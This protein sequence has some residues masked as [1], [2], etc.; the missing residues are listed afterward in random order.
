MEI[1]KFL[2]RASPPL[3]CMRFLHNQIPL[4]CFVCCFFSNIQNFKSESM[5]YLW[6]SCEDREKTRDFCDNRIK[7]YFIYRNWK[8]TSTLLLS[9]C[10][11]YGV[12]M[13]ILNFI[14][15]Q[16][17]SGITLEKEASITIRRC[18][19][20]NSMERR[21]RNIWKRASVKYLKKRTLRLWHSDIALSLGVCELWM[22][23][24]VL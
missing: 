4:E 5:R 3:I 21:L 16:S 13:T 11:V 2:N 9:E 10:L 8:S 22:R 12:W 7:R 18:D 20:K 14:N 23:S 6:W 17:A 19:N 24:K 15:S 1:D